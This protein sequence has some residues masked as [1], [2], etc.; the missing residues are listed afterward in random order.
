[1]AT[2]PPLQQR[3]YCLAMTSAESGPGFSLSYDLQLS[4][5]TELLAARPGRRRRRIRI[6]FSLV[7]LALLGVA[8]TALT[9]AFDNS[10]VV[11]G[12]TG[13][14]GWM[15]GSDIVIWALVVLYAS[16]AWRLSPKR[17]AR[18]TWRASPQLHGRHYDQ[19]DSRGVTW[20]GPDG[21]QMFQP[22]AILERVRET[23]HAF[24]L[25]GG[26]GDVRATLPKRGLRSPDLILA[27]R[28]FL[29]HSVGGQP[30]PASS[31]S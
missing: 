10:S 1:M 14:P 25:Q 27:L 15:V 30:S 29:N 6:V 17:L 7:L 24:H 11:K 16:A 9:I 31:D 3:R 28:E 20:T 2:V 13:A 5:L 23:E 26:N 18:R 19:I 21:T 4:D 8:W 12:S 22:W